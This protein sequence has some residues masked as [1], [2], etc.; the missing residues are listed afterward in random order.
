MGTQESAVE[1]S[2][3]AFGSA[4]VV[5]YLPVGPT[6]LNKNKKITQ[7]RFWFAS[8]LIVRGPFA[9]TNNKERK[10]IG[11]ALPHQYRFLL[12][13]KGRIKMFL[14][15]D[16]S[17]NKDNPVGSTKLALDFRSQMWSVNEDKSGAWKKVAISK[18]GKFEIKEWGV[19][20]LWDKSRNIAIVYDTP[21]TGTDLNSVAG[22]A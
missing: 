21:R 5:R 16:V 7:I 12:P 13:K 3:L 17:D 20:W 19:M 4:F 10:R 2:S 9:A 18:L 8:S 1:I 6:G 15:F 14:I 11:P 22:Q